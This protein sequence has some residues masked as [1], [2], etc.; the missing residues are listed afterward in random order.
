MPISVKSLRPDWAAAR[1]H[2]RAWEP[3]DDEEPTPGRAAGI[4][5]RIR[6]IVEERLGT[7]HGDFARRLGVKPPQL[8]RWINRPDYPPSESYLGRIAELGGVRVAWLRY[9]VGDPAEEDGAGTEPVATGDQL[10]AED[11]FRHFE[12]MVRRMGGADVA[13][14]ELR[15]RKLDV[16]EGLTRLYAAGGTIPGWVYDLKGRIL[17]DEL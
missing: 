13:P 14:E 1:H 12:G 11:L 8:S 17:R 6:W 7:T 16:V 3:M 15:L 4:G 9:G 5:D 10:A 2:L